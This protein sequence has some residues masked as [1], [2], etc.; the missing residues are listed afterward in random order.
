[1]IAEIDFSTGDV[2]QNLKKLI[3][4]SI[5]LIEENAILNNIVLK[6]ETELLFRKLPQEDVELHLQND[7]QFIFPLIMKWQ[8]EGSMPKEDPEVIVGLMRAILILA[9]NKSTIG[10]SIYER[11]IELMIDFVAEG[12]FRMEGK[13]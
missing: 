7:T 1:L 6:N 8:E 3:M 4:W 9:F 2:K 11:T 10:E 13:E 5:K 12:L